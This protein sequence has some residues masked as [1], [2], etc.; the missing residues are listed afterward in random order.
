MMTLFCLFVVVISLVMM[1]YDILVDS[2]TLLLQLMCPT[3]CMQLMWGQS[4][5]TDAFNCN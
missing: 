4:M 5:S 1:V 3:S 2:P